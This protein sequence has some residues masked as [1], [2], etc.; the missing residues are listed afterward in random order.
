METFSPTFGQ[1]QSGKVGKVGNRE[2]GNK[3]RGIGSKAAPSFM[4][5]ANS[6]NS[7]WF[8]LSVGTLVPEGLPLQCGYWGS[9]W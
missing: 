3:R 1:R 5:A 6:P 2:A 7:G 4:R 9:G 8:L